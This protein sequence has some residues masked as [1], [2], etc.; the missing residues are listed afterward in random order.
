MRSARAAIL[1]GLLLLAGSP[2]AQSRP[3]QLLRSLAV[4]APCP[5]G[6]CL[7]AG[8][9]WV[10]DRFTD[11]LLEVDRE[12]GAILRRLPA[13]CLQPYG[14]AVDEEGLLWVGSDLP[15][16]VHDELYRV[17]PERGE[18]VAA[19]P[20]PVDHVRS[21]AWDGKAL[22]VG[23][24]KEELVRV[25]PVDGSILSR[26]R[27]PSRQL[28]ALAFDGKYLWSADRST[29][30]I[31]VLEPASGEVLFVLVGP[32]PAAAGLACAENRLLVLDYQER[33]VDELLCRGEEHSWTGPPRRLRLCYRVALHNRGSGAARLLSAWVAVPRKDARQS[34]LG[35]I[36]WEPEPA[37]FEKD[38]W[39]QELARFE[40][41]G[42]APG[43]SVEA[44][45]H[46]DVEL[47]SLRRAIFPEDVAGLDAIPAEVKARYLS[48]GEKFQLQHPF[49][50]ELT[51]ETVAG[52]TNPW[53]IARRLAHAVGARMGYDLAGGW[54]PAPV[55]LERGSGSCSEYTFAFLALCRIAGLPAR[56]VG[57][58]VVRGEDGSCD[59][60]FHRWAQVYL[61][62]FGWVDW[63]VQAADAPLPGTFAESLCF[64]GDQYLCTTHGGGPSSRLGWDYNSQVKIRTTGKARVVVEK[65]GEWSPLPAGK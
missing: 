41:A 46:V 63:D 36:R 14:L 7:R 59:E 1:A 34:L 53:W 11:L 51:A 28:S 49:L 17:D 33:R 64:R 43:A 24:R 61:P 44:R 27:A 16:N 35:P 50:R 30:R 25:D 45:M 12:S 57:A 55:V 9:L 18:V 2:A 3:G 58:V 22:W 60:T 6:L 20:S 8:R 52:E 31:Y 13:P 19:V 39:G 37:G 40:F 56:Y 48:D 38:D 4:D 21:L 15:E 47:R 54:E 26:G 42:V 5:T 62:P 32:G 10:V 29:D 65:Y 23:T